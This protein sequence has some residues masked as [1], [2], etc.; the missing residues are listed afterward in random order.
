M[1]EGE[2]R[3]SATQ[4][5]KGPSLIDINE[6]EL[7]WMLLSLNQGAPQRNYNAGVSNSDGPLPREEAVPASTQTG[8]VISQVKNSG[9]LESIVEGVAMKSLEKRCSLNVDKQGTEGREL[10]A[11]P[12]EGRRVLLPPSATEEE[13]EMRD[14]LANSALLRIIRHAH[15]DGIRRRE[16]GPLH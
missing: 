8:E 10:G 5:A 13:D 2:V 14:H 1:A 9:I 11:R 6:E 4:K 15:R 3:A 16:N 12:K 7:T